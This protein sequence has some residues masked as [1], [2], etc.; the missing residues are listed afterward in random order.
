MFDK[1]NEY[2]RTVITSNNH[3]LG[4]LFFILG[5]ISMFFLFRFYLGEQYPDWVSYKN[6]YEHKDGYF[7][8]NSF[9]FVFILIMDIS[10]FFNL[11]YEC[12]RFILLISTSWIFIKSFKNLNTKFFI[13]LFL[14]NLFFIFFQIRQG[15]AVALI[16]FSFHIISSRKKVLIELTALLTHFGSM[17]LV[18]F[19]SQKTKIIKRIFLLILIS[20]LFFFDKINR[21]II[22]SLSSNYS[23]HSIEFITDRGLGDFYFITPLLYLI[24]LNR[25]AQGGLLKK[26]IFCLLLFFV[27]YPL[28]F[29]SLVIPSIIPNSIFR[30]LIIYLSLMILNRKLEPNLKLFLVILAIIS[31]DFISSQLQYT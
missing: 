18:I 9:D 4:T 7:R 17:F 3:R 1:K 24:I 5:T 14:L 12:F 11:N 31:K 8:L 13:F 23:Q 15:L 26:F 22:E 16:Y 19:A 2:L 21:F 29:S 10:H 6:I 28:V 25:V 30:I 20:Y 27:F